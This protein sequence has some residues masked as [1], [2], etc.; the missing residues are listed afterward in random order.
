MKEIE[1]YKGELKKY[2]EIGFQIVDVP[3]DVFGIIQDFYD[4]SKMVLETYEGKEHYIKEPCYL[5]DINAYPEKVEYIKKSLLSLHE[6]W[7]NTK[8]EPAVVY[9]IRSYSKGSQFKIHRDRQ[10]THHIASTIPVRKD[11]SWNLDIQSHDGQWHEVDVPIGKMIM[12]ES[13]RCA[14]GRTTPLT[15]NYYDNMYAHY[16]VI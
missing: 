7:A 11:S 16:T 13:V 14:H 10:D 1:E 2:T 3:K 8:L 6:E 15:G 4:R 12:F 9:G 5:Q